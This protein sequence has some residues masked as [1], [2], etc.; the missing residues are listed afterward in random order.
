MNRL[1]HPLVL[2]I[3]TFLVAACSGNGCGGG[4]PG[5][6]KAWAAFTGSDGVFGQTFG[7]DP[8][9]VRTVTSGDLYAV[10]CVTNSSGWVAGA[11]GYI[12]H[13][14]D[15][16]RSFVTEWSPFASP[17][18]AL[19]FADESLGVVAGDG[20][21]LAITQDGGVHWTA[22]P[23]GT[24]ATLRAAS[25]AAAASGLL[26]VV[27]D[28]ATL[29]TSRDG[30]GSWQAGSIDGAADLHGVAITPDAK[31]VLAVDSAGAVWSSTDAAR[32]F[33]R[34]F[35]APAALDAVQMLPTGDAIAVGVRGTAVAHLGGSS[36]SVLSTGTT[37]E[38]HAGAI[39]PGDGSMY[40]AGEGGT[41]LESKDLGAHFT[42]VPL[43]MTAPILAIDAL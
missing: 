20:G 6:G 12:A 19:S 43:M 35:A 41:L 1:T 34:V 39:A 33:V 25:A 21:T 7:D 14:A 13:T 17:L 24:H 23:S 15:G 26:L 10:S 32:S 29:V 28:G 38:L 40:V 18:R 9:S 4:P 31:E 36:W 42:A 37:V 3:G 5:P 2:G 11:N 27:G 22:K 8:W 16:G 30:G